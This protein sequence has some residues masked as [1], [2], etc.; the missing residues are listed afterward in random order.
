VDYAYDGLDRLAQRNGIG[1]TYG[2][3]TNNPIR[4]PSSAGEALTFRTAGGTPVSSKTGTGA[5]RNLPANRHG[6]LVAAADPGTAAVTASASYDPHGQVTASSGALPLGF[7]GG[8]VDPDTGQVNAYARSYAPATGTF[9]SR[10]TVTL[11]PD[12]V[13]RANRYQYANAAPTVNTDTSGHDPGG[14]DPY[15]DCYW[16]DEEVFVCP[17]E[18]GPSD[19]GG[20]GGGGSS[21]PGQKKPK[22][23][24]K[25]ILC[26][27]PWLCRVDARK[28]LG[29]EPS[30]RPR[31]EDLTGGNPIVIVPDPAEAVLTSCDTDCTPTPAPAPPPADRCHHHR[32]EHPTRAP[33]RRRQHRR[34]AQ[35]PR[36]GRVGCA[37][38][39][40]TR[41]MGE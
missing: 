37:E 19:P 36:R 8:W 2:D 23:K 14:R 18:T 34:P 30:Q 24:C 32:R 11:P 27:I 33:A 21:Q 28:P 6:D 3:L 15:E 17:P 35:C 40:L 4:S 13:A 29:S 9:T 20:G 26:K 5:A 12:P 39:S 1:Y 10:D 7:Q 38:S 41:R 31:S 16:E 22:S 25:G